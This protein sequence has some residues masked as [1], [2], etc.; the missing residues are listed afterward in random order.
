MLHLLY[1]RFISRALSDAGL[2][3]VREPFAGLFTQGM[4]VHETYRRAN[5]AGSNPRM[6]N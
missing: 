6:S 2:M 1:A 5:G 3:S 4:V